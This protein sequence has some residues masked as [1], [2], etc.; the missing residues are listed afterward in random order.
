MKNCVDSLVTPKI[1]DGHNQ[2][3]S[4]VSISCAYLYKYHVR[5]KESEVPTL[6]RY[7]PSLEGCV[8]FAGVS[9]LKRVDSNCQLS[10]KQYPFFGNITTVVRLP[11]KV[12]G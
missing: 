11:K 4:S 12:T 6:D 5:I 10:L 9:V 3:N 8:D 1:Q 2:D 7:S